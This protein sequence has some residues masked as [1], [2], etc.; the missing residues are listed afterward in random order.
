MSKRFY[1]PPAL[2]LPIKLYKRINDLGFIDFPAAWEIARF[3]PMERHHPECSFRESKGGVLCDCDVLKWHTPMKVSKHLKGK[4]I[5]ILFKHR[6][7]PSPT[8]R[9]TECPVE[10]KEYGV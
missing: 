2:T 5:P 6:K 3:Y 4:R 1:P 8:L 10:V 7:E 9:S